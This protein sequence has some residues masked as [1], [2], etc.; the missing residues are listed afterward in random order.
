MV[1][2]PLTLSIWPARTA[3]LAQAF[4]LELDSNGPPRVGTFDSAVCV[5]KEARMPVRGEH[6]MNGTRRALL[7]IA[8]AGA[9]FVVAGCSTGT[10]TVNIDLK[11]YAITADV[12]SVPA[13][14][15]TL[16]VR[17]AG[18]VDHEMVVL[19]TDLSPSALPTDPDKDK[20]NEE[21]AGVQSIGELE[22]IHPGNTPSKT[23]NLS[24]GKYI[25]VCNIP[26]HYRN[27]M[28]VAFEVK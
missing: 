9:L 13:G 8:A 1:T 4:G 19:K 23:F 7:S 24:P 26:G 10:K 15:V 16:K 25:F 21:G 22:D 27:G 18:D 2:P 28:V 17:N 11:E 12:L 20:V 6:H 3:L 5:I 14:S